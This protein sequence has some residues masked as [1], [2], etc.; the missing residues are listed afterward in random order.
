MREQGI[1]AGLSSAELGLRLRYELAREF[2]LYLGY[3]W[4]GKIGRSAQFARAV[5]NDPSRSS[6]VAGIRFWF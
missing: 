6:V 1:G 2:A 3:V 5:G 4:E